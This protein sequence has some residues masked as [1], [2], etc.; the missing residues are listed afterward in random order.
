MPS[1]TFVPSSRTTSGTGRLH[2]F[3]RIHD[4]LRDDVAPHDAAE[5]VHEDRLHVLVR[6]EKLERLR[7]LLFG[8]AAADV[9]EVRRAA[10]VDI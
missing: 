4:A 2:R 8:R 3:H 1:L 9:E 5:N 7:H 10:A 6:D